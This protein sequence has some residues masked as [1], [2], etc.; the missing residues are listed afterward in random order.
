M[1]L[2]SCYRG[3]SVLQEITEFWP[4]TEQGGEI[5]LNSLKVHTLPRAL[6]LAVHTLND[7]RGAAR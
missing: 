1:L 3:E 4:L 6:N 5:C 7:T 2:S